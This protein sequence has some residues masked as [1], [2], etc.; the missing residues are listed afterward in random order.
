MVTQMYPQ[1]MPKSKRL[2]LTT[3]RVPAH[4]TKPWEDKWKASGW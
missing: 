3:Y 2:F 1:R 4:S